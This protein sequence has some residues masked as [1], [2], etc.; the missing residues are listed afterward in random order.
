MRILNPCR[1]LYP[2]LLIL[3]F[4]S[5]AG[6]AQK[7]PVTLAA[8]TSVHARGGLSPVWSPSGDRFIYSEGDV[9]HLVDCNGAK[10]TEL[11]RLSQLR[12]VAVKPPE[13]ATFD[14]TNRRVAAEPV[15]W[16]PSGTELLVSEG[17]DLFLVPINP[18]EPAFTQ[19]T[20]T[21]EVEQDAK[22][23]PDGRFVGFRRGHDLFVLRIQDHKLTRLTRDGG[24]TLLNGEMDWVYPE[25]LDLPTAWW[26]S[27]DN[28][29]IAYMQFDISR[30]PIFPQVS[31]TSVTGKLEPERYPQPGDPNPDVRIG[32]VPAEGGATR[33]L[34][35]GETRGHL[36]GRVEW[37]PSGG[38]VAVERLNRIQNRL[39]LLV[40]DARTGASHVLLHEE[41]PYWINLNN[42]LHFFRDG[43]RFL[44]GSERDGFLHLYLYGSDGKLQHQVT[45]G[46]WQVEKV[47]GVDEAR[48]VV[49]Y[50]S[51]EPGPLESQ[52][53]SIAL[54]GSNKQRLSREKGTHSVHL[55][56]SCN[57]WTDSFS[58]LTDPPRSTLYRAGGAAVMVLHKPDA[59]LAAYDLQTPEIHTVKT[60]DGALLYG[61]L[62]KPAGF[63]A[64]RK[65]PIIV[66]VYGGPGNQTVRDRWL[67]VTWE[68]ALAQR[69]FVVWQMD[70][71]GSTGRGHKFEISIFRNLGERELADQLLGLDYVHSLGFTDPARVGLYGWSYGGYMTLYSLCNAPERFQ[72]GVAGAPVT[73]WRTYDS[74]YTERYMGLPEENPEAYDKTSPITHAGSLK[75]QLLIIHNIEDDNVHFQNTLRMTSALERSGRKFSMLVY[76]QKSHAV[77]GP[78]RS[79]MLQSITD[80]FEQ[81]LKVKE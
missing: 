2:V 35:L 42:H 53:Y 15:Q 81:V 70:N 52:F 57:F 51:T 3:P 13:P 28:R 79:Q 65:Y 14:W 34:D 48:G 66:E 7:K 54:D 6:S 71:R 41:D 62:I 19:L 37:L 69:G 25:E 68:E 16:L 24:P 73:S 74:I 1:A 4:L 18:S 44:W 72:A 56:P 80:F 75:A 9:I 43:S 10:E 27:P 67:G 60:P 8:V 23:S 76:P 58:S 40:A 39:D 45:Q 77:T 78:E 29:H 47:L 11:V 26:W 50:Q 20:A 46:D 30:E 63:T 55:S 33:W 64:G 12:A 5:P 31:L 61:R 17:G 38:A 59:D 22:L 36:L 32:V 21:A 49:Y